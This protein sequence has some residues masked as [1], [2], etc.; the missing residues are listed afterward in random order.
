MQIVNGLAK[1]FGSSPAQDA[2]KDPKPAP[3]PGS[4]G[5]DP[6]SP[7]VVELRATAE[8][9]SYLALGLG[10]LGTAIPVLIPV[11]AFVGGASAIMYGSSYLPNVDEDPVTG[12]TV[13]GP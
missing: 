1:A 2:P 8:K 7:H 3:V 4:G 9:L 5:G 12:E 11:A 13:A 10:A 6:P